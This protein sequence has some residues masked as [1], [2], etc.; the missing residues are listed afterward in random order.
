M[1]RGPSEELM[2]RADVQELYLGAG[3][4]E[5]GESFRDVKHYHRRR[6]SFA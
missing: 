5:G 4:D 2:G 6:P 3:T 1:L